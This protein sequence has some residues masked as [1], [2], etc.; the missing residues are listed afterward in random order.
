VACLTAFYDLAVSPASYDFVTFLAIADIARKASNIDRMHVV[1][2][3][4]DTATGFRIDHKPNTTENKI[5]RRDHLLVPLCRLASASHAVCATRAD[6]ERYLIA[7]ENVWPP[8]YTPTSPVPAYMMG[9][10]ISLSRKAG[11]K[12]SFKAS[13]QAKQ[14]VEEWKVPGPYLTLTMR[15]TYTD[16]RNSDKGA[17]ADFRKWATYNGWWVV[18]IPDTDRAGKCEPLGAIA[19]VN[20]DVRLA[21]YE[22]AAMNLGV[23]NGPMSLCWY[24]DNPHLTFKMVTKGWVSTEPAFFERQG[25]PIGSQYP[26]ST[27]NQKL[28]WE[29]DTFGAIKTHFEEWAGTLQ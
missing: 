17:W 23:N 24:T 8:Q 20:P 11:I 29:D 22:G 25:F 10:L 18:V 19:A 2:V 3:P 12:A 9:Q 27:R 7:A 5:W 15:E 6:A 21:L 28:V 4:A 26:H 16:L 13:E 1:I 14:W